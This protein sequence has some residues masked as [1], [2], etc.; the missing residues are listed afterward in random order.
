MLRSVSSTSVTGNKSPKKNCDY[1]D[2]VAI[3]DEVLSD[4]KKKYFFY[5]FTLLRIMLLVK[6]LSIIL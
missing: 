4:L 2:K 1:L 6:Q 5:F 3:E